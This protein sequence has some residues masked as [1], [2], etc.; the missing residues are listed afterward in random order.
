MSSSNLQTVCR[1]RQTLRKHRGGRAFVRCAVGV[2]PVAAAAAIAVAQSIGNPLNVSLLLLSEQ[3]KTVS[4]GASGTKHIGGLDTIGVGLD[5]R[6]S[7]GTGVDEAG[8]I[9]SQNVE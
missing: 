5:G 4:G 9:D 6:V 8:I 1:K 2:L 3:L 7:A